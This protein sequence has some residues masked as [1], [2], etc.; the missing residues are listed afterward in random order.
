[1][2]K[3]WT[4]ILLSILVSLLSNELGFI[5]GLFIFSNSGDEL[6]LNDFI[7]MVIGALIMFSLLI[8]LNFISFINSYIK[9]LKSEK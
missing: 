4:L 5:E 7:Y 2:R 9:Q 8:F 3:L 1:M 6:T